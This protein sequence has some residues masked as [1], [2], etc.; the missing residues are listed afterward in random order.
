V[1]T[2]VSIEHGA[3]GTTVASKRATSAD[4]V[5]A[6]RAE[7][8]RLGT[9][10]HPG[11]VRLVGVREDDDGPRLLTEYVGPRT[12]ATMGPVTTET[13]ADLVAD[14]ATTVADLHVAGFVHGDVRPEHVL[15]AGDR[16]VLCSPAA[17]ADDRTPADDV[18]GIGRC[19]A[20]LLE[21]DL[22]EEPIPDRRPWRR[23]PWIGYRHR[24][25]LTLADQATDEDPRRR[26]AARA[27]ADAV[28]QAAGGGAEVVD[29]PRR[30][31]FTFA[32]EVVDLV[33]IRVR[34]RHP[35]PRS[36]RRRVLLLAALGAVVATAGAAGL[37]SRAPTTEASAASA[38]AS[39]PTTACAGDGPD[40]DGDGCPEAVE[41]GD[42]W[43][44]V[45]G[46]RYRVGRPGNALAL[47]DWDGDGR[48][49]V[50]LLQRGTGQVWRFA[51]WDPDA[52]VTA[53]P[54]GHYPGATDLVTEPLAG[55]D[56]LL[57]R[58]R[59]GTTTEVRA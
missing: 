3:D 6:I 23:T 19:L 33:V 32:Q 36:P 54:L 59:D 9:E 22:D 34:H 50:A 29:E 43:I 52:E 57:V 56:R 48:A 8:E 27:L 13:A 20:S 25:L 35:R 16:T 14:L 53:E 15:V 18:L 41:L 1:T 55:H 12:M 40:L 7:A 51:A 17:W 10:E 49:T 39:P 30:T 46:R 26:P 45:D 28:R 38:T 24:A 5:A 11:L 58:G 42:G 44:D 2:H 31:V 47:G 37:T 21:P 4:A